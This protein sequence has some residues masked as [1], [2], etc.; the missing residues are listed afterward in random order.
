VYSQYWFRDPADP[1]GFGIGLTNAL[2]F[3]MQP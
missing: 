2:R 3:E 1:T